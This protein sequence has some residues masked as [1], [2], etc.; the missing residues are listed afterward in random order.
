MKM[1]N[2]GARVQSIKEYEDSFNKRSQELINNVSPIYSAY[3]TVQSK[4]SSKI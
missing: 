2:Q 4:I 3:V 1:K